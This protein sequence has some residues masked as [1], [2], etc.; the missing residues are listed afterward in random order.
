M[1]KVSRSA[2][3]PYSASQMYTLV[4]DV[5]S[6]PDFLPWCSDAVLHWRE[7]NVLEGSV[8]M[9]RAGLRRRFRTRNT[10]HPDE[11]IDMTLVDGPFSHLSGGWQ[12]KA[13]GTAGCKVSLDMEFEIR[14]R[15]TDR[16]LGRYF[17]D[18]C[19]SLVDAF[20]R[21][22]GETLVLAGD[23]DVKGD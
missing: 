1:R 5:E 6:Y 17:E 22:A 19:N 14:S 23:D 3:V 13:L 10:M 9:H 4:E 11:A 16:L 20:V 7:G 12:F 2:L 8:E 18:I 15:A 21:R